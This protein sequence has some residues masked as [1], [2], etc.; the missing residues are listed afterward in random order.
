MV[1][2]VRLPALTLCIFISLAVRLL[3][4]QGEDDFIPPL[5]FLCLSLRVLLLKALNPLTHSCQLKAH[6]RMELNRTDWAGS[7]IGLLML[8]GWR[9]W[10]YMC[11]CVCMFT[12]PESHVFILIIFKI[13]IEVLIFWAHTA[14]QTVIPDEDKKTKHNK[15]SDYV[16]FQF[17]WC[18]GDTD[19][20]LLQHSVGC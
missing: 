2:M 10:L 18:T 15:T 11:V 9:V 7:L 3:N 13:I 1:N 6:L 12:W 8:Q 4:M 16:V 17:V 20:L 14:S 5:L 19:L